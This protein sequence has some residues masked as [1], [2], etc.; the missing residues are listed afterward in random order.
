MSREEMHRQAFRDEAF[1]LLAELEEALLTLEAVPTDKEL[2]ARVF[3]AM[4]TI[5]GSGAMFGFERIAAFTHEI[6][7]VFDQV[8]CGCLAITKDLLDLTLAAR[9]RIRDM[10]DEDGEDEAGR[11][12]CEDILRGFRAYLPGAGE[13]L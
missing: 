9:D 8:R 5:K 7:T 4:H 2:I 13:P 12:R 10:L 11:A 1:D 3:R 6:E